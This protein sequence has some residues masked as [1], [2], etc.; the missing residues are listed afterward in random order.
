MLIDHLNVLTLNEWEWKKY[1]RTIHIVHRP[2]FVWILHF[3]FN[4]LSMQF[5]CIYGIFIQF[6]FPFV[7]H[8]TAFLIFSRSPS[9]ACIHYSIIRSWVI[10]HQTEM[11]IHH[12]HHLPYFLLPSSCHQNYFHLTIQIS[13]CW[14]IINHMDSFERKKRKVEGG[15]WLSIFLTENLKKQ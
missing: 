10:S 4:P 3:K 1:F 12:H 5:V 13:W 8:T 14:K 11:C 9:L 15:G 2:R 7:V 6:L